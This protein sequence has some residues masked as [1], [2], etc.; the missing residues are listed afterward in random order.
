MPDIH[1]AI[2]LTG[3]SDFWHTHAVPEAGLPEVMLTDGPHGVRKQA[4]SSDHIGINDSV[5]ATC[6]PPAVGLASTWNPALLTEVGVALGEE[7]RAMKVG[8]LLGPGLNIKRSPLCGRNFEYFSED[9]Y[10]AGELAGALVKGIQSQ[11]IGTSVKHFAANNQET[12]RMRRDSQ[13]DIRTLREIYLRGFQKVVTTAKPWTVMCS[14]N[15]VNGTYASENHWLLTEVLRDEWGFDGFVMSDWG[16]VQDRVRALKAGLDLEM[17]ANTSHEAGVVAALEAGQISAATIETAYARIERVLTLAQ[18]SLDGAPDTFDVD[19][20]HALARRAAEQSIV[21]L[22]NDGIL[23]LAHET[24]VAVVGEFARTPRYQG[25]GSSRVNPTQLD[26]ALDAIAALVGH[27]VPFAAGFSTNP[28]VQAAD[29]ALDEA[30]AV[31]RDADVVLAFL[32]LGE[33]HESEGFDRSTCDLPAEQLAVLEGILA[34]N[35][36]VVVVLSNGSSVLLTSFKDRVR[37][38]VEGWLLGQAGGPAT[39]D[40]LYGN[41][42][43]SGK[44]TET[45]PYRLEDVPSFVNFPGDTNG[46]R[47]GEGLFVGYRGYDATR[48]EVAFP[49]GHGLSYTTFGYSDLS[50]SASA[51]GISVAVTVTN[52]GS[53]A[54]REVVQAYV[55]IAGSAVVRVPRELKGFASVT[56]EPGASS[57]VEIAIPNA[58]LAFWSV[59]DEAWVVE[60]GRY[61]VAVGSSSRDLPLSAAVDVTGNEPVRQVTLESTIREALAVPGFPEIMAQMTAGLPFDDPDDEMA[62]MMLDT[63]LATMIGFAGIPSEQVQGMLDGLNARA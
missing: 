14:Y 34:V 7:C 20:H 32:G 8:V 60:T 44:I 63:P 49:F 55:S 27:E 53:R 40:V 42:N 12:D 57:T 47:Y 30:V 15:K 48:T 19:G 9:P 4:G 23:P 11:G 41:V 33:A 58:E 62:T 36:N 52:T 6:F 28:K 25:A 29:G 3:G 35:P 26:N 39:A 17:P 43:P 21:L 51:D 22:S 18:A 61:T 5:P 59:Q 13:V 38:I 54:G 31:A 37:A 1:A 45:I 56:L 16:A 50:V 24:K 2:A 46:V 10:V